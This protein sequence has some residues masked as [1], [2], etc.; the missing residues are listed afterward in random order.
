MGIAI[1]GMISFVAPSYPSLAVIITPTTDIMATPTITLEASNSSTLMPAKS[2]QT[3]E[4]STPTPGKE[5]D[6]CIKGQLEWTFPNDGDEIS[7][8]VELKGIVKVFNLGFYKYEYSQPGSGSWVTIAAGDKPKND[9]SLG[10]V[11]NTAQLVPGDYLLR[12]VVADNANKSMPA[13]QISVRIV[14]KN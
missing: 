5:V 12:L 4:A 11:L 3:V 1:F 7:G 13:C 9:E 10:G 2:L 8:T 6:G 14:A